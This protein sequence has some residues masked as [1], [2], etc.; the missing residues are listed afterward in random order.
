MKAQDIF[1]APADDI[2][3][4]LNQI[5]LTD[6]RRD[7]ANT[8]S[9]YVPPAERMNAIQAMVQKLPDAEHDKT[10]AGS[11]IGAVRYKGGTIRV[12]PKGK[13][14]AGSAGLGNEKILVDSINSAIETA[15]SPLDIVFK[16]NNGV[17]W[18]MKGVKAAK[19]VGADTAGRKKADIVLDTAQGPYYISLKQGNAAYWESA[20]TYFGHE[21]DK[22]VDKLVAQ[23][24]VELT[25][26]GK[27]NAQGRDILKLNKEIAAKATE[28]EINDLIFGSDLGG[29][30]GAVIKQTFTNDD[31]QLNGNVMHIGCKVVIITKDDIPPEMHLYFLIRNDSTRGRPKYKYPG[32]RMVASYRGRAKNALRVS[33]KG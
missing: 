10:F 24:H 19:G 32:L 31:F 28:A 15:G 16:G 5:G 14:G 6:Q 29:E 33:R 7:S 17:D 3:A 25:P 13:A 1:E 2:S 26:T 30:N 8:V 18:S 12:R 20:D 23:G 11:S 21:A 27:K 9:V 4:D 22:I